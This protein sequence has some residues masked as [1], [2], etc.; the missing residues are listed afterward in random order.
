MYEILINALVFCIILLVIALVV[1][2]IQSILILRETRKMTK[3][4]SDKVLAVSSLLDIGAIFFQGITG[5][6][7]KSGEGANLSAAIA[8]I[9]KG[10]QVFLSKK[11]E[12]E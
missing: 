7:R 1:A 2:V 12:K 6:K 10:L 3:E 9:K 8:G 11:E 5:L 4:V